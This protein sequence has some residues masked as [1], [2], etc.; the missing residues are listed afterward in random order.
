MPGTEP[1]PAAAPAPADA[2]DA[3]EIL[4]AITRIA[5]LITRARRHD[6]VRTVAAVPWYRRCAPGRSES[7]S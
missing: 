5:Y 4:R 3:A 1:E 6:R 2:A 7:G